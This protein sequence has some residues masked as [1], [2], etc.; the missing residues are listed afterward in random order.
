[1]NV[2]NVD[3]LIYFLHS[4]ERSAMRH[5]CRVA[6]KKFQKIHSHGFT[7]VEI[8]V[9]TALI[10]IMTV[11]VTSWLNLPDQFNKGRDAQRKND[12]T[13]IKKALEVYYHDRGR[14]PASDASYR[15]V[16]AVDGA[17]DW[18]GS[19]GDYMRELPE[20]PE[21][22]AGRRYIYVAS[23]D[24]QSYQLFAA[25]SRGGNDPQGCRYNE[26]ACRNNPQSSSCECLGAVSISCGGVCNFSATSS[27]TTSVA[28]ILTPPPTPLP[29]PTAGAAT[30]TPTS[31][32]SQ[33]PA[34]SLSP[35]SASIYNG[36]AVTLSWSATNSPTSCTASSTPSVWSGNKTTPGGENL[37][38]T[39][40]SLPASYSFTLSC[41]NAFGTGS[42]STTVS[43]IAPPPDITTGLV[44]YWKFDEGLGTSAQDSS[45][46]G[47]T[48]TLQNAPAWTL[49]KFGSGLYFDGVDDYVRVPTTLSLR[50][51][52]IT[53]AAWA[54]SATPAWNNHGW[55]V[56]QRTSIG[57]N[58]Y[59]IHPG[60]GSTNMITYVGVNGI[61][62]SITYTP[63]SITD[64]HHYVLTYDGT[65]FRM[66]VDGVSVGTPVT[67]AGN[68]TYNGTPTDL[69]I[70]QDTCCSG[71]FGNG[72]V[73]DVRIYNRALSAADIASLYNYVPFSPST[74]AVSGTVYE[75]TNGDGIKQSGESGYSTSVYLKYPSQT[76]MSTGSSST[77]AF[78]FSGLT[79]GTPDV[80]ITV[81]AG[82][83]A[84]TAAV[85][86]I[87]LPPSQTVNFG[88]RPTT[89]I[90]PTPTTIPTPTT[91]C[92][93][94]AA[95][96]G[97]A[98]L[99]TIAAGSQSVTWN[100]VSGATY[101]SLRIDDLNNPWT[102]NCAI[103]NTG[104]VCTDSIPTSSTYNFQSG[105]SYNVWVHAR[106][107]CGTWSPST[108]VYIN[109]PLPTTPTPIPLYSISGTLFV[110]TNDNGAKDIGEVAYENATITLSGNANRTTTT[111][112]SGAY[113]FAGL[114]AG[115]YTVTLTTVPSG[116]QMLSTNPYP[117][118]LGPDNTTHF[119]IIPIPTGVLLPT[120][121]VV[122]LTASPMSPAYNGSTT[123]SWSATNSPTSCTAS[124]TDSLWT[125]SKTAPGSQT[126]TFNNT[127]NSKTYTF[128][129]T[130]SN[131]GG[132]DTDNVS[133]TVSALPCA[134]A[135]NPA[136]ISLIV[137]G[138][139]GAVSASVTSGL[140]SATV[141]SMAFGSYNTGIATVSPTSD[142]TSPYQTNVT[143]QIAGSTA[144]WATATLSDG[145][146]C[147]STGSTDTDI[148]VAT[149]TSTPT[150][151]PIPLYSI[152]GTLFV[153]ADNDEIQD[154]GESG[155][156]GRTITLSG[157]ASRTATTDASGAYSF[158]NLNAGNYTVT[159]SI[160]SGYYALSTNPYPVTLGPTSTV[161]FRIITDCNTFNCSSTCNTAQTACLVS[162]TVHVVQPNSCVSEWWWTDS[163]NNSTTTTSSRWYPGCFPG[164]DSNSD[165]GEE[166]QN[167]YESP[168]DNV[169][170]NALYNQYSSHINQDGINRQNITQPDQWCV[171]F[172]GGQNRAKVDASCAINGNTCEIWSKTFNQ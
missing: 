145:R 93:S 133:V 70:G 162:S 149:P 58:G 110:D 47:N 32:A 80:Y 56:S 11:A 64:W 143:A 52:I 107:S 100:A 138:S 151:T 159:A 136:S 9:A 36:S 85:R 137:G 88:L 10:G 101:Y 2:L 127:G 44:G 134:V 82:W 54:K 126:I 128:T 141:S 161:N 130:C 146:T 53:V 21:S 90:T 5:F 95:P 121:P 156:E 120:P 79:S 131:A 102:G 45:G 89:T 59:I 26:V 117:V 172:R 50:P 30:P 150:P 166:W 163:W 158:A 112:A 3:K 135:T 116:Y 160:P 61:W 34:V 105:H 118:V 48:G 103:V 25:L 51:E 171:E 73:D 68:I 12:L 72:Q 148:T 77:G 40:A 155:Y 113:S 74:Y 92:P 99:D 111:S 7:L 17:K 42:Q 170:R 28:L 43:V 13:E 153:D 97:L 4:I 139:T 164:W 86:T 96:T 19:W 15:I 140:G 63:A 1:M 20:D 78:A 71:R 132:D 37:I 18:G 147:Q 75:D 87:A 33:V 83:Q 84:T 27:N 35:S 38:L 16:D 98:P 46:I 81:P 122:T 23:P 39:A 157:A 125:G 49:G 41:T 169:D 76:A 91:P 167:G 65:A 168:A 119:R 115:N 62:N 154:A 14:Y 114:I 55:V 152:S 129:L 66:Y 29:T 69:F 123:L 24:G 109:V 8:L 67:V 108:L 104:D 22:G 94:L 57:G 124:S 144:V 165:C 142:T 106:N 6:F 60:L 31:A